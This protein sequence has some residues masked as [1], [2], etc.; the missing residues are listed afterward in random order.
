MENKLNKIFSNVFHLDENDDK[1]D[2]K[3]GDLP[4]WD[5][6]GHLN[7]ITSLEEELDI[8]FTNE[9]IVKINSFEKIYN[10]L[11]SK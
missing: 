10:L 4:N 3:M 2:L 1:T 11:K 6:M 9:E 5:S 8:F 7:L